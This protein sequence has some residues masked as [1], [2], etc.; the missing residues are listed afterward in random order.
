MV[1]NA[2]STFKEEMFLPNLHIVRSKF[3]SFISRII[4]YNYCMHI[5]ISDTQRDLVSTLKFIEEISQENIYVRLD[6][7]PKH[8]QS[9]GIWIIVR[10]SSKKDLMILKC[11]INT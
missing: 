8:W 2:C 9:R 7:I 11:S 1:L 10:C 3:K 5:R 4:P 6:H